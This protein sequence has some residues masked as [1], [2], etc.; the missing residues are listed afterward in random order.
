MA[1]Y[2]LFVTASIVIGLFATL[3]LFLLMAYAVFEISQKL[4]IEP[5]WLWATGSMF[6]P[7]VLVVWLLVVKNKLA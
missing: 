3:F 5:A 1:P 7:L 6:T 2:D 4:E